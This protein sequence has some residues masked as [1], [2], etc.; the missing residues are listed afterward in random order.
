MTSNITSTAY[1]PWASSAKP[2]RLPYVDEL[3]A[4]I[5]NEPATI[6][7][8]MRSGK[9]DYIGNVGDSHLRTIDEA[10]SLQ[11]TNPEM[12]LWPWSFRASGFSFNVQKARDR[13]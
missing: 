6:L 4:L 12:N 10:V 11:R 3:R 2:N 5:S 8:L 13:Y 7:A 1:W 9:A